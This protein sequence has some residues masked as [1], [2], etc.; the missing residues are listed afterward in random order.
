[1][2][3]HAYT[4]IMNSEVNGLF[5]LPKNVRFQLMTVLALM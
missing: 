2:L 3:Y 1:M 5:R 4:V